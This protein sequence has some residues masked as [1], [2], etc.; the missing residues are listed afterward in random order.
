MVRVSLNYLL[1]LCQA[2]FLDWKYALS[3]LSLTKAP[4]CP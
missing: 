1:A 4:G 2:L 3:H